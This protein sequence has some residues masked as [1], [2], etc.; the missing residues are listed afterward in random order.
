MKMNKV[1]L[2]GRLTSDID[3]RYS[4]NGKAYASFRLAVNRNYVKEGEER[5]ADFVPC[6]VFDKTAEFMGRHFVK[7][8][9]IAV[10]GRMT[11]GSYEKDGEKKYTLDVN[12]EEVYFADS[13]KADSDY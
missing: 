13:K 6:K 3:I 10:V 12:I 2:I 5:Q 11:S 4:Q 9:Q 8:S 7:G 1:T